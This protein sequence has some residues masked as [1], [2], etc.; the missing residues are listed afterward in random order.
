M[1]GGEGAI[2][3]GFGLGLGGGQRAM[4][5]SARV[6]V[7]G[8]RAGCVA[9]GVP[10]TAIHS[11]YAASGLMQL[12]ALCSPG[13]QQPLNVPIG[14]TGQCNAPCVYH[15][16]HHVCTMQCTMCVPRSA[17]CVY[18]AVHHVCTTQCTMCVP[19][20]CSKIQN[21]YGITISSS[22]SWQQRSGRK[23]SSKAPGR[24]QQQPSAPRGLGNLGLGV[25][26]SSPTCDVLVE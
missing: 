13:V 17:P 15:A 11:H 22:S 19:P 16:V 6:W 14:L 25:L 3:L 21:I 7:V 2:G 5:Y 1:G 23:G 10:A 26:W 18:H 8:C 20:V 12:Q 4:G 9:S 24:Q